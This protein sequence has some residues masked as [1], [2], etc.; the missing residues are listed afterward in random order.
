M[1]E[2]KIEYED[3]LKQV[4]EEVDDHIES[5]ILHYEKE[6][7]MRRET[8]LKKLGENGIMQKR[9]I[10]LCQTIEDQKDTIKLLLTREDDAR[11]HLK[12]LKEATNVKKSSQYRKEKSLSLKKDTICRLQAREKDLRKLNYI[13]EDK[14]DELKNSTIPTNEHIEHCQGDVATRKTM[15]SRHSKD[16]YDLSLELETRKRNIEE[17]KKRMLKLNERHK[18]DESIMKWL[19]TEINNLM[20]IIQEPPRLIRKLLELNQNVKSKTP[21]D[22]LKTENNDVPTV[23]IEQLKRSLNSVEKR[24]VNTKSIQRQELRSLRHSNITTLNDIQR[25][26]EHIKKMNE[27]ALKV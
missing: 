14:V 13:L 11:E 19:K 6:L 10:A 20:I 18:R 23:D 15:L 27:F 2:F 5:K 12:Q 26:Q 9:S 7:S 21:E 8:T 4:E 16:H 22:C 1:S 3:T 25:I 17:M 24:L